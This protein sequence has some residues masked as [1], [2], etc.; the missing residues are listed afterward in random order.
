MV[1]QLPGIYSVSDRAN[2]VG[3]YGLQPPGNS[4]FLHELRINYHTYRFLFT[5]DMSASQQMQQG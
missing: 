3:Q 2:T 5:M 1:F 4:M